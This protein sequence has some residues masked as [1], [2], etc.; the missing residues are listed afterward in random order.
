MNK[1]VN[2]N[3]RKQLIE[4]LRKYY[5]EHPELGYS[6]SIKD[7]DNISK[8]IKKQRKESYN[9]LASKFRT[10][11]EIANLLV[12]ELSLLSLIFI[13][14]KKNDI[15]P[16]SEFDKYD[17]PIINQLVGNILT[18]ISNHSLSVIELLE[19]GME[20]SCRPILRT[21]SEL[22]A[23]FIVLLAVPEKAKIYFRAKGVKKEREVWYQNFT[24][25]KL[26]RLL[27]LIKGQ[28]KLNRRTI[29][30]FIEIFDNNHSFYSQTTH[31]ST[32]VSLLGAFSSTKKD[33]L[34]Y[35]LWGNFSHSM[36]WRLLDL[37]F[38]NYFTILLFEEILEKYY[39]V[40]EVENNSLYVLFKN[41]NNS[42]P[43]FINNVIEKRM[44]NKRSKQT[45]SSKRSVG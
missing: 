41:I 29:P 32:I 24:P 22:S 30:F 12:Y 39:Q 9:Q 1:K 15:I 45:A 38:S 42:M 27:L 6:Y 23:L 10:E 33:D 7:I 19:S 18:L 31:T 3:L 2:F 5:K 28:S 37:T 36:E 8:A 40:K 14:N 26:K 34:V 44:P 4:N 21:L 25:S 43:K 11:Y 20:W 35:S 17:V 13:S 16:Q